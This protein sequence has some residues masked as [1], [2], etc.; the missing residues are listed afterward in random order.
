[1]IASI[2][3]YSGSAPAKD[4]YRPV[5][6]CKCSGPLTHTKYAPAYYDHATGDACAEQAEQCVCESCD[7]VY[8]VAD[9]LWV[10]L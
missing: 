8:D 3:R 7:L 9:G 10:E 2:Q 4:L 6:C 5:S 1:M